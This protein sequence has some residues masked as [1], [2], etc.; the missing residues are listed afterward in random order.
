[1]K[2]SCLVT[3]NKG[4]LGHTLG[5]AG[6]L[7]SIFSVLSLVQVRCLKCFAFVGYDFRALCR[8]VPTWKR[9]IQNAVMVSK[10]FKVVPT[11]KKIKD[12]ELC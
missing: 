2:E 7:E 5:A 8:H 12:R 4:S 9:P 1:M 11:Q 10:L 6:A 3:S